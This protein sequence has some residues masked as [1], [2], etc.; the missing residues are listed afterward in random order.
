MTRDPRQV[1]VRLDFYF[2]VVEISPEGAI[3][4]SGHVNGNINKQNLSEQR[5]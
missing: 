1:L 3:G 2:Y 5:H 4:H